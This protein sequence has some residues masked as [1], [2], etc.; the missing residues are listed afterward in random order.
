MTEKGGDFELPGVAS[1][2]IPP[3]AAFSGTVQIAHIESPYMD[4]LALTGDD[5][6]VLLQVPKIRITSSAP[7][8][9]DVDLMISIPQ[10]QPL[11]RRDRSIIVVAPVH[12]LSEY[13]DHGTRLMSLG[14]TVGCRPN[15]ICTGIPPWFFSAE[16]A[17]NPEQ[18]SIQLAVAQFKH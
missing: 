10:P 14:D 5:R 13:E 8:P 4:F 17:A 18:R 16:D 6:F 11:L 9:A 2:L 3:R 7:L 15:A 12:F 1:L